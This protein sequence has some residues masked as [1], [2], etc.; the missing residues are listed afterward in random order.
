[1]KLKHL[2]EEIQHHVNRDDLIAI[3]DVFGKELTLV[4]KHCFVKALCEALDLHGFEV[5]ESELFHEIV[6][7]HGD[8]TSDDGKFIHPDHAKSTLAAR[9][10]IDVKFKHLHSTEDIKAALRKKLPVIVS[11]VWYDPYYLVAR[12]LRDGQK[13]KPN[14]FY[15]Y[16][17]MGATNEM[18]KK[19]INGIVP[20]PSEKLIKSTQ[21]GE[22]LKH[23]ILCVGYDAGDDAFI[24]RDYMNSNAHFDGFFKIESKLFFDKRL[25]QEGISVVEAAISVAATAGAR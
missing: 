15:R 24:V 23:A 19:A 22:D 8:E 2:L 13:D 14:T 18:V 9:Y 21:R 11:I 17:R 10:A 6:M 25:E 7:M 16:R 3:L 20:Y 4:Y 12:E 1:M 5:N